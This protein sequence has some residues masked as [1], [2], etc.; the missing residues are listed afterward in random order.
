MVNNPELRLSQN[1]PLSSCLNQFSYDDLNKFKCLC[2]WYKK[3]FDD[4]L[5]KK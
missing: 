3:E 5:R 4:Y 1:A 2:E